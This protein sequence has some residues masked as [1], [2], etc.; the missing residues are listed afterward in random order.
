[1]PKQKVED[2]LFFLRVEMPEGEEFDE[3]N[4]PT[5]DVKTI[6]KDGR[7]HIRKARIVDLDRA[8]GEQE[9]TSVSTPLDFKAGAE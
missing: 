3:N 1:M 8:M 7:P 9:Y 5:L 4:L 2:V 6:D